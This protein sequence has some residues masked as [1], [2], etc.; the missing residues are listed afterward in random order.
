MPWLIREGEVLATLE[1]PV[2]LGGRLR[3][4]MGRERLDGA[5]LLR[6]A[7]SVHTLGCRFPVD[8]AYC[9]RNLVVRSVQTLRPYRVGLPRVGMACV[10]AAEAGAFERWRLRPEDQLEVKG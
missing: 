9:D 7:W 5:V 2:A 10:V 8:L 4:L 1:V 6:P 3:A